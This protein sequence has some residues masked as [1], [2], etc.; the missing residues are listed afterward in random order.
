MNDCR[1]FLLAALG[2][3]L[4]ASAR[5][6]APPAKG[7]FA[8][9]D[10]Y[11][12]D[13]PTSPALAP[14]GKRLAFVRHWTDAKIRQERHSLWLVEG[15]PDTARALEQES[16]MPAHRFS[17]R[18]ASG[19]PS[20]RRGRGPKAG[21]QTPPVA[22]RIGPGDRHLVDSHGWRS[23]RAAGRAETNLM[24]GYSTT[25]FMAGWRFHPTEGG[26]PSSPMTARTHARRRK[27]PPMS[28][29]S[30]P[31]RGKATPATAPRRSG[32]RS[33]RKSRKFAARKIERVTRDE[34]W[35][36]DPQWSRDGGSLV[37][38]ANKTADRESV[39][40][41][42]NKNF[43]LWGI[44]VRTQQPIRSPAARARKFLR[45]S[46]PTASDWCA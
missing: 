21:K 35:Y 17:R 22:A 37:I 30:G 40:Y 25:A 23:E 38:H 46:L 29:S 33:W 31:T 15:S 36:G 11:R 3:L 16:R 5:A 13:H 7:P 42:I 8:I 4:V 39:R 41:S 14:D 2:S 10:L 9:E 32:S 34:V 1:L 45:G 28:L 44:D 27:S 6:D 12:M 19:S 26:L 24:V 20:C 43:D 18:T